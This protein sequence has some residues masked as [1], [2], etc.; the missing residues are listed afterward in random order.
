MDDSALEAALLRQH[1]PA[2]AT[3]LDEA[4]ERVEQLLLPGLRE[5]G[6]SPAEARIEAMN[7]AAHLERLAAE[8]ILLDLMQGPQEPCRSTQHCARHGW[9]H[10]CD[11]RFSALMSE[12]NAIVQTTC[13][14]D[15]TWGPLYDQISKTLRGS[16]EVRLATELAEAKETQ[17]R[18]EQELREVKHRIAGLE[19]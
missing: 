14:D 16:T 13:E 10:R 18:L 4:R 8:K 5:G 17:Q 7:T 11:G 12:I 6:L 15:R 1:R 9:C 19:K 2:A 3:T